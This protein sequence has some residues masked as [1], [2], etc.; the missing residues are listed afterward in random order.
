M[1]QKQ[2]GLRP[3]W[4]DIVLET[5]VL[6]SYWTQTDSI[7]TDNGILAQVLENDDGFVQKKQLVIPTRNKVEGLPQLHIKTGDNH[8]KTLEKYEAG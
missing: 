4:N 7:T 6:N 5:S 1:D 2:F 8:K 3:Y